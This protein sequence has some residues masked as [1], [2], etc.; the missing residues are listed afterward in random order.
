M[1]KLKKIG[2]TALGTSLVASSAI[3]ADASLTGNVGYTWSSEEIG[4][5]TTDG[6]GYEA[7]FNMS[8]SGE[9]DNGWTAT[10]SMLL[11]ESA[12]LSSSWT[13]LTMGSLGTVLVGNGYGGVGQAFDDV[14]PRAYEENHDGMATSTA[15]DNIG[16]SMDNGQIMYMSPSFDMMGMSASFMA[17]YAPEA[18]DGAVTD[19]AVSAQSNL[20]SSGQGLGIKLSGMGISAGAYA[21][22][23][24]KDSSDNVVSGDSMNATW[25]VSYTAGPVSIGYQTGGA[26]NALVTGS[27]ADVDAR[28]GGAEAATAAKKYTTAGGIF[29]YEKMSIAANVNDNFSI[30]W[31]EL[32]ETYDSQS[33]NVSGAQGLADVEMKSTSIQFAY[34]MGSMSVKG[35]MTDTDNPGWDSDAKSD[36]VTEL[37]VGFSF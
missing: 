26:D 28:T 6:I 7:D 5:S 29:E 20:W 31:G 8:V 33:S 15:I 37:A 18:S 34:S 1:N 30:S 16:A 19:G 4:T 25:H 12:T 3:A 35:Y 27:S 11:T 14:T 10:G 22:E 23:K 9:M 24:S 21:S 17:E 32:K 13:S 2:L 36:E